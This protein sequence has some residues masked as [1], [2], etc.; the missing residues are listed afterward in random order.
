MTKV[1][2]DKRDPYMALLE[3][4]N[5]PSDHLKLAPVQLMFGRR[6]RP[7]IPITE[8]LVRPER[9]TLA[10]SRL[11]VA[12]AKQKVLYDRNAKERPAFA[13]GHTVGFKTDTKSND[14]KK[15]EVFDALPYRSYNI[16]TEDG[17]TWR[18][19]SRHVLFSQESPIV[20]DD[21]TVATTSIGT[22]A[23]NTSFMINLHE[24]MFT[25]DGQHTVSAYSSTG[26]TASF[27]N[28]SMPVTSAKACAII[29]NGTPSHYI[30]R[31]GCIVI[32]INSQIQRLS[33]I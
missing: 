14:W 9:V 7:I 12:N 28:M 4:Q 17:S 20:L 30:I 32:S 22:I 29:N 19:T 31:S 2:E 11:W 27:M 18:R 8:A 10:A 16:C 33:F 24:Q 5:T 23:N 3:W 6:I 1:F 13:I 26:T 21:A 25:D 15:G